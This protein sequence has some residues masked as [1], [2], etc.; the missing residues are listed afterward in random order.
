MSKKAKLNTAINVSE[1]NTSR[2]FVGTAKVVDAE[3]GKDVSPR[4]HA[5]I[6]EYGKFIRRVGKG[7]EFQTGGEADG[8]YLNF[9]GGHSRGR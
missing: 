2:H 9:E 6:L 1:R 8:N 7:S 3:T 5:C 4:W